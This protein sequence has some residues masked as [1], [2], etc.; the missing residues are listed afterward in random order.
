M[1][2]RVA[3]WMPSCPKSNP[4]LDTCTARLDTMGVRAHR[5]FGESKRQRSIRRRAKNAESEQ[6]AVGAGLAEPDGILD[7]HI[8]IDI[9]RAGR[10]SR[11]QSRGENSRRQGFPEGQEGISA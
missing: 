5:P 11:S 3:Q 1:R 10:E 9:G 4:G 2:W 8:D 6:Q 7:C